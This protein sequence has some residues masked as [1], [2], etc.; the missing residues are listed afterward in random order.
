[1]SGP[2]INLLFRVK[3]GESRILVLEPEEFRAK[4]GKKNRS[5][6]FLAGIH[7]NGFRNDEKESV[8]RTWI[9]RIL[10]QIF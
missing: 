7:I 10:I 9:L 2:Q 6:Y 1:M 8:F 3:I 4:Y 5:V